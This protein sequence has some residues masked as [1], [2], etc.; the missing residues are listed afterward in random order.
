MR[1][2]IAFILLAGLVAGGAALYEKYG[3]TD[4]TFPSAR[5]RSSGE[6]PGHGRRDRDGPGR[7]SRRHRGPGRRPDQRSSAWI[8]GA[9]PIPP[10]RE[11]GRLRD[12]GRG[13]ID[14]S[15]DRQVGL[16]GPAEPGPGGSRP[17]QVRPAATAG[18]Q[19]RQTGSGAAR[20]AARKSSGTS[21]WEGIPRP[22]RGRAS[23]RLR[24]SSGLPTRTTSWPGESSTSRRRTSR[25]GKSTIAQQMSTLELADTN[26]G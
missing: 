1:T 21:T 16:P 25:I 6:I 24:R 5:R 18:R 23:F 2:F 19:A 22:A 10:S 7:G 4:T 9:R 3:H 26:L 14:P 15:A 20:V 17:G 13:G 11:D 8:L 12:A